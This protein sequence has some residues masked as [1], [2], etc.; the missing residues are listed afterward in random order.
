M[1]LFDDFL[2]LTLKCKQAEYYFLYILQPVKALPRF[3]K[4]W[5]WVCISRTGQFDYI[6]FAY[7]H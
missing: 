1:R 6:F 5:I 7:L 4:I 2:P 3:G